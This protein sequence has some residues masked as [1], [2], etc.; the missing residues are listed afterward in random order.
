MKATARTET[1]PDA[2]RGRPSAA[3][4][5]AVLLAAALLAPRAA[6]AQEE[7][8]PPDMATAPR[9]FHLGPAVS[10]LTWEETEDSTLDD[11]TLWGLGVE[12]LLGSILAVRLDGGFGSGTVSGQGRA[13]D[14]NTYLAEVTLAVRAPLAP[15]NRAGVVPYAVGGAGTVV[16]DP[17][18][19]DLSTA[20]QN[21]FSY[22]LGVD[23]RPLE[24]FGARLEWKRYSVE[25]EDLLD[26][27]DRSGTNRDADRFQ[28]AL[29]WAF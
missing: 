19:E 20:S 15:L 25:L 14:V 1:S 7:A 9:P 10:V 22:G 21:A 18:D 4:A 23:V 13:L 29:Y 6:P 12:R 16:H 2:P 17:S 11:V 24:R 3:A 26:P 8:A 28:A 5:A 27:I